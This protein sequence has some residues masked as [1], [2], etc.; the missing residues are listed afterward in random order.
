M[1]RDFLGTIREKMEACG[2]AKSF[3]FKQVLLIFIVFYF[4]SK[5]SHAVSFCYQAR[6]HLAD[7][8][9]AD[10]Q[11]YAHHFSKPTTSSPLKNYVDQPRML[12]TLAKTA[13]LAAE[14]FGARLKKTFRLRHV[15]NLKM[16]H[17][18][19]NTSTFWFHVVAFEDER[20]LTEVSFQAEI[21][22]RDLQKN[23]FNSR[24]IKLS[25][26]ER[27]QGTS[28]EETCDQLSGR[29]SCKCGT[30]GRC[31]KGTA[32]ISPGLAFA[33]KTQ[34][35]IQV[36]KAFDQI[37]MVSAHNAFNDRADGYGIFDDCPWP[38][39]YNH[40]CLSLANQEFSFTDLLDMGVRGLEIDPWWC[41]GRMSMSHDKDKA[42]RGCAPWDRKYEDGIKEIGKWV[43]KPENSDEII[44]LY[45]EDGP[46]HTYGHDHLIN[47]PIAQ[48]LGDRVLTPNDCKK[49]F[50]G[51]WP[52]AK[53]MREINKTVVIAGTDQ[54]GGDYIFNL[55]WNEMT[56][57]D[58]VKKKNC[59]A[60]DPDKPSRVYCDS[61]EYLFFWNGPEETGVIRDFLQFMKCGVTYPAADQVNPVLLATAV[62]TW[63][64]GEPSKP[65]TRESCVHLSGQAHRWYVSNC[66]EKRLFACQSI[67]NHKEWVTSSASGVYTKPMCPDGYKFSI[68]H[69]GLEHQMLVNAITGR[70]VWINISPYIDLL[71]SHEIQ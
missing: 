64:K 15:V 53:E 66:Q 12:Y 70:D 39:P 38:P 63:A 60:I 8:L 58:F 30:L 41:F 1:L 23:E 46:T 57:N 27:I 44:R 67:K 26:F 11:E 43:H 6:E 35:E 16:L 42:Y 71:G 54:H 36:D 7:S 20:F 50:P 65:L 52:T 9:E 31:D 29:A 19:V 28:A 59:S 14:E 47:D 22:S 25:E 3:P 61:T 10:V 68:P 2:H 5:D 4:S 32:K 24:E 56:R 13:E 18:N 21:P 40:T 48:F 62:F 37:Q 17:N 45:F 34:R 49:H 55:Y 69:D 51:R 33:L